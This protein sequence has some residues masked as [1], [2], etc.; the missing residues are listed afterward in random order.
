[1]RRCYGCEVKCQHSKSI[2]WVHCSCI[3]CETFLTVQYSG[4]AN[5]MVEMSSGRFLRSMNYYFVFIMNF[6]TNIL[7]FLQLLQTLSI[8]WILEARTS[9]W[10][11]E[12]CSEDSFIPVNPTVFTQFQH[13]LNLL[14]VLSTGVSVR[15]HK[16]CFPQKNI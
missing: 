4:N 15:F 7:H 14:R 13:D 11:L 16:F 9:L 3:A 5:R 1:M 12:Y 8:D 10:E 2:M 6:N